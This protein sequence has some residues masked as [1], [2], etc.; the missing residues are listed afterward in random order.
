MLSLLFNGIPNK[1]YQSFSFFYIITWVEGQPGSPSPKE[2]LRILWHMFDVLVIN[3][4]FKSDET[5]FFMPIGAESV[6]PH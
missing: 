6:S 1:H 5:D 3:G 2:L 4:Q